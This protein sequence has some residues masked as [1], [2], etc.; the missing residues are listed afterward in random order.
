MLTEPVCLQVR[1]Q[2]L[3]ARAAVCREHGA[4]ER[5]PAAGRPQVE[6]RA[7]PQPHGAAGVPQIRNGRRLRAVG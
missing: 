7:V 2:R 1:E 5:G 3:L 6:Q 4:A